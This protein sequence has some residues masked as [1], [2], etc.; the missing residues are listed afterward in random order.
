MKIGIIGSNPRATAIGRL[1]GSGD[2][3]TN[4]IEFGN[5]YELAIT[6]DLL[7]LAVEESEVDDA[8]VQAGAH[9]D[10]IVLD[11]VAYTP[12]GTVSGPEMLARKLDSHCVVRAIV[13][14][15]RPNSNFLICGDDEHAKTVVDEAFR[16]CGCLTTDRGP[17]ANDAQ[18]EPAQASRPVIRGEHVPAQSTAR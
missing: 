4:E 16:A 8:V 9:L 18:L 3:N 10:A 1:L 11:V 12:G 14:D 2:K 7:V 5:P 13:V 6:S 17:L 15:P